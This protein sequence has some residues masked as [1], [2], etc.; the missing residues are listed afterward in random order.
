MNIIHEI[1]NNEKYFAAIKY[2]YHTSNEDVKVNTF[3]TL[4]KENI[5]L[6]AHCIV[7][8]APNDRFLIRAITTAVNLSKDFSNE[9]SSSKALL[10]LAE[11]KQFDQ[12]IET[13]DK[14]KKPAKLHFAV[15]NRVFQQ[16]DQGTFLKFIET[17]IK[18][19]SLKLYAT[20]FLQ[21]PN[22]LDLKTEVLETLRPFITKLYSDQNYG[23]LKAFLEKH[24]LYDFL[25][26]FFDKTP[27]AFCEELLQSVN[28]R[29]LT[30]AFTILKKFSLFRVV[31]VERIIKAYSDATSNKTLKFA[32]M[33]AV[34]YEVFENIYLDFRLSKLI[35]N[36]S[37][38]RKKQL[39]NAKLVAKLINHNLDK[40][41]NSTNILTNKFLDFCY[42]YNI[43][44]YSGLDMIVVNEFSKD[45]TQ[46]FGSTRLD[47]V[48]N[49]ILT[50][51]G[52]LASDRDIY[53]F[54]K[55]YFATI[56]PL[57]RAFPIEP[58][59]EK[60]SE[61]FKLDY[62]AHFKILRQFVHEGYIQSGNDT[63]QLVYPKGFRSIKQLFLHNQQIQDLRAFPTRFDKKISFRLI[64]Y[65][66]DN[67]RLNVSELAL[68]LLEE[69]SIAW[70]RTQAKD[71]L[72]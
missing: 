31:G 51:R 53:S 32:L 60:V 42:I 62:R 55:E 57:V 8:D 21:Y 50:S 61:F 10:A 48:V 28:S 71:M 14:I 34:E 13:F 26:F 54:W 68:E 16:A 44:L 69:N 12:I 66:Q 70:E 9:T 24:Q 17:F 67:K 3:D 20:S 49:S 52:Y 6:A 63:G 58:V 4:L 7:T 36:Q 1:A 19:Q 33:T 43:P 40:Y 37:R 25:E 65:N 11:L 45:P 29:D 47:Q 30:F 35:V 15:L 23:V 46:Y 72:S 59:L 56:A 41:L 5:F 2:Y 22:Q 38:T 39:Q 18:S 27:I 64:G